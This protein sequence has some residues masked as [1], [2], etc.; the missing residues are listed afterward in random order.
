MSLPKIDNEI[1][2]SVFSL[3][4]SSDVLTLIERATWQ[5]TEGSLWQR[6]I[7]TEILNTVT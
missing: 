4:S 3:S 1:V 7:K 2:T 6:V 5:G